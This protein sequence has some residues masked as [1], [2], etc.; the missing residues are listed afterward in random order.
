MDQEL[1]N[2]VNAS[3]FSFNQALARANPTW[4][5]PKNL[6]GGTTA[7]NSFSISAS[8]V[9]T[10]TTNLYSA[11]NPPLGRDTSSTTAAGASSQQKNADR[12]TYSDS[13]TEEQLQL[14]QASEFKFRQI[15]LQAPTKQLCC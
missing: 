7:V 9:A 3:S 11:S 15:P 1:Q 6:F 5:Q 14:Y 8:R 2:N 4:N 10:P 13:L 12:G